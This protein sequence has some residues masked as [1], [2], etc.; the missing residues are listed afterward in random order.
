MK[1]IYTNL[2]DDNY[3]MLEVFCSLKGI[4][5]NHVINEALEAYFNTI[6]TVPEEFLLKPIYVDS[7]EFERIQKESKPT[8]ALKELLNGN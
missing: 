8:K 1:A 5:K 6:K 4:K 2:N 7:K 3:K